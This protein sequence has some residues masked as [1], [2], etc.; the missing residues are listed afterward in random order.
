MM[1]AVCTQ[2]PHGWCS[3][4]IGDIATLNPRLDAQN[5]PDDA[6]VT[7]VPMSAVE[8]GSGGID[9]SSS[10]Y[11]REVRKGYTPFREGDVLFAKITPCME[12][13]KMA[14]VPALSGGLAF[15]STEFHVL[16]PSAGVEAKY[17]Y[18]FVSAQQ[19]RSEAEHNM[20]GAVGQ[21]RVP[22]SYLA[23]CQCPVPPLNEQ[24]RIVAKLE[25]LLSELD[26]GI[27]SLKTAREQLKVYRQALLKH[28]F[29]GK[30][31]AAW[32]MENADKLHT[33]EELLE[34]IRA[35]HANRYHRQ[36]AEWEVIVRNWQANGKVGQKPSMPRPPRKLQVIGV[37]QLRGLPAIPRTSIYVSLGNLGELG[38]GRSKHRPRN[39]PRLFGGGYP[40]IQTGEVKAAQ[41]IVR[42][43]S[44]TYNALGLEQS[45]LWPAGTLCITIAANIAET[46]FLGFNACFPD[47]I[48]GFTANSSL[49]LPEYVEL[50]IKSARERIEAYAPATAQKNINLNTLE[51]LLIPYCSQ[52][53]QRRMVDVLDHHLSV[54]DAMDKEIENNLSRAESLRQS[55]LKR[56][57]SGQLVPQ[58]PS[59]E[60]ASVLLE[61]I[62]AEKGGADRGTPARRPRRSRKHAN[63]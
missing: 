46:A 19:F 14:V 57:F 4:K 13:G 26:A 49:I 42:K 20:T 2:L 12:N 35:E 1:E 3:V 51:N 31:T 23:E 54:A 39:D 44:Q 29:E 17:L 63:R 41:R 40:F 53:E 59:D 30:L 47:S 58:D 8:A 43:H 55:I 56:A 25:E 15:G 21:R 34:R 37:K 18:Y 60:P 27:E 36:I 9:V 6:L 38:R 22:T 28:A 62:R 52:S 48:V 33:A 32:R 50:F 7:F 10:R 16:R 61:R 24:R 45:K 11:F 5:V